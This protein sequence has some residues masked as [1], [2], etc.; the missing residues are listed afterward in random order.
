MT[1]TDLQ[2]ELLME[3][4]TAQQVLQFALNRE[5]GQENQKP[6]NSQLNR[7]SPQT[8]EQIS[9][10]TTNPRNTSFTPRP[11]PPL[12]NTQTQRP[13]NTANPC[14]RCGIQFSLEQLQVCPAKKVQCNLCKKIGHYSKVCRSAKF[15]WQTQH[16]KPQP[17]NPQQI[18]PQTGRV[19]NIRPSP[20]QQ[21]TEPQ[22]QE[23]RPETI[24]ETLDLEN[25]FYI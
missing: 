21:Q 16:I 1:N 6:I 5:R 3:T 4:R 2:R 15:M 25:T 8:F 11:R 14:R 12:R 18:F 7:Y 13:T 23:T 24:D 10:I 9:N 22:H 17:T 19:R 20:E